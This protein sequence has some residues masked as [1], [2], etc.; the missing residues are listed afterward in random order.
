MQSLANNFFNFYKANPKTPVI[1]IVTDK[2][3][4]KLSLIDDIEL[5]IAKTDIMAIMVTDIKDKVMR[6]RLV[7]ITENR[8]FFVQKSGLALSALLCVLPL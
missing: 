6:E 5:L 8:I 2:Q 1:F 7:N 3:S 4:D